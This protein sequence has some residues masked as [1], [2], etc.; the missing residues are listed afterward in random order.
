MIKTIKIYWFGL[1]RGWTAFSILFKWDKENW[2]ERIRTF[3]AALI[4][5]VF[6]P[7]IVILLWSHIKDFYW[8]EKCHSKI[9][10]T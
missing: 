3:M 7:I 2:L 1:L 10:S 9:P 6:A 4:S 8:S 5:T